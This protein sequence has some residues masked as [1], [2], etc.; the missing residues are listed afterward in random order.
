MYC[1]SYKLCKSEAI[2]LLSSS[3]YSLSLTFQRTSYNILE[4][5]LWLGRIVK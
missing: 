5:T 2:I 4:R 1:K 3:F